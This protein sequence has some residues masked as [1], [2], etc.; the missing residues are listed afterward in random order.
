MHRSFQFVSRYYCCCCLFVCLIDIWSRGIII[1]ELLD[2]SC[3]CVCRLGMEGRRGRGGHTMWIYLIFTYL[4][5]RFCC[6]S[7]QECIFCPSLSHTHFHLLLH[8]HLLLPPLSIL[9]NI[10]LLHNYYYSH[11]NGFIYHHNI[12]M[13]P[14]SSSSSS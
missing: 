11:D 5:S 10:Y 4:F 9:V 12:C 1:I 6:P 13:P 14:S 2:F 8:H 3:V 7:F